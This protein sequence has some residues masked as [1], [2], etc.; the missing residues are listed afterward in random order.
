MSSQYTMFKSFKMTE[1]QFIEIKEDYVDSIKLFISEQGG[2]YPHFS[3]IAN[4]REPKNEEEKE[5]PALLHIPIP[6]EYLEDEEGK[7]RFVSLV[8]PKIYNDIVKN[9][10]PIA[11]AWG[12]E[13]YI[14]TVPK[15]FDLEKNDY[16]KVPIEKEIVIVNIET[17]DKQELFIY[18]IKRE[19]KQVNSDGELTD[20]VTLI[21]LSDEFSKEKPTIGGRFTGFFKYL[22]KEDDAS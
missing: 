10:H 4:I 5:K 8:F 20:K 9:F 19:G 7:E 6:N 14:R 22:T 21:D 3:I 16:K 15:D 11:I 1:Q 13:A 12:S 18:E 17:M 2:L